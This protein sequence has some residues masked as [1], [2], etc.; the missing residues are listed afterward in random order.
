MT[1]EKRRRWSG[2]SDELDRL[3]GFD[4]NIYTEVLALLDRL[5][6]LEEDNESLRAQMDDRQASIAKMDHVSG[7][8][9]MPTLAGQK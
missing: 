3:K 9:G 2:I 4:H 1:A 6:L 5:D 8:S 7:L